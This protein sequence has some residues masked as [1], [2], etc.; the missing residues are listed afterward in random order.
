MD[1]DLTDDQKQILDTVDRLMKRHL[2]AGRD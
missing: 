1:F 2:S